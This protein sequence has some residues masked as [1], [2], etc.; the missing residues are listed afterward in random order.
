MRILLHHTERQILRVED[1]ALAES[2]KLE[3]NK[4]YVYYK[5]SMLIDQSRS[6]FKKMRLLTSP[7]SKR[8]KDNAA[9]N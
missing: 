9:T 4:V 5:P 3:E 8:L 2:L 6:Y 7:S 1:K